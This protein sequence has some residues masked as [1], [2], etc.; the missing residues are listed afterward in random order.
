MQKFVP[1]SRFNLATHASFHPFIKKKEG[2]WSANYLREH[3]NIYYVISY[4]K[5]VDM[6]SKS[7]LMFIFT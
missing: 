5:L 6:L 7:L 2:V 1:V 3:A 4:G